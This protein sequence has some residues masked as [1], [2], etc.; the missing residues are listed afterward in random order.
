MSRRTK[1]LIAASFLVLLG[2]P[3]VY[4]VLTWSPVNP[5]EARLI[6]S[7]GPA[8]AS[9]SG[10]GIA[11]PFII[12]VKNTSPVPIHAF[13]SCVHLRTVPE[14]LILNVAVYR[15]DHDFAS[16]D[17]QCLP[18]PPGEVRVCEAYYTDDHS[19]RLPI[20]DAVVEFTWTTETRIRVYD[21]ADWLKRL[22]PSLLGDGRIP[23]G[24]LTSTTPLQQP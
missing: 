3:V 15:P 10:D 11:T 14:Y 16:G 8:S 18:I 1:L 2:I 20:T 6:S 4:L 17:M 13:D 21:A 12:E 24:A 22:V 7:P 5:L 23:G 9:D 19:P